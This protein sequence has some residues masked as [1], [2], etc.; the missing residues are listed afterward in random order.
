MKQFCTISF[1]IEQFKL[2]VSGQS[3]SNIII[4]ARPLVNAM[5]N[6]AL[7]AGTESLENYKNCQRLFMGIEN[8]HVMRESLN[9]LY[10]TV[11]LLPSSQSTQSSDPLLEKWLAA[12]E[13]SSWVKHLKAIMEANVMIIQSILQCGNVLIHCRFFFFSQTNVY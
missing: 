5:S 4:D 8:I 1:L 13:S 2:L 11:L 7:G 3:T 12:L 6:R 9:R 10:D